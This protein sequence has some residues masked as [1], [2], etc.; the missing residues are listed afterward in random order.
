M[1]ALPTAPGWRNRT[2][3]APGRMRRQSATVAATA[4]LALA[5]AFAPLAHAGTLD[6]IRQDKTLRIAYRADAPPFSYAGPDGKPA[7]FIIDL[8]SAVASDVA[9][10]LQI[11]H[12]A[13]DYVLVSAADRFD[14]IRNGKADLLCEATTAT[15]S[16]REL[17]DFS[18]ATFVDGAS[19][20]IRP[21]GPHSVEAL[22]GRKIGVLAG[23]TTEEVL[24]NTL[25]A[26]KIT[27]D[28]IPVGTHQQGLAML[29]SGQISAYFADRSI[30]ASLLQESKAPKDLQLATTYL[31]VE[32]YALALPHG[33]EDFRLAVDR[34]LSHI[35]RS[36]AIGGIL[37]H[38][39]AGQGAPS[40]M[41][42]TL[43]VISGLPD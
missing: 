38:D 36:G 18:I 21:D 26:Y 34:A 8:C 42:K 3:R 37:A 4:A 24:R 22:A 32:P 13:I 20:M 7:G 27:A 19:I 14:A 17:V 30:L 12:L 10:Q 25:Q 41:L 11:P 39:F 9:T 6:R 2:A 29:D 28:L 43:Y 33:D 40:D 23:T 31:T 1:T 5:A 16:R 35:Y 15:L